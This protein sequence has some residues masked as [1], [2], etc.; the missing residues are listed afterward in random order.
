MSLASTLTK[1]AE[2]LRAN[3]DALIHDA[4]NEPAAYRAAIAKQAEEMRE[5]AARIEIQARELEAN[6]GL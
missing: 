4:R 2:N 5:N 6:E 1:R 3:A